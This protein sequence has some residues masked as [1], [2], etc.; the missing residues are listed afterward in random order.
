MILEDYRKRIDKVDDELLRLMN[1]RA[2]IVIEIER[3]K[4]EADLSLEDA[5]R[6]KLILDRVDARNPG[7]L[8]RL[9]VR[10]I[11]YQLINECKFGR[12]TI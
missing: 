9:A 3:M 7:P 8:H 11:F 6:E 12:I 1:L 5:E 10:N 2:Q 4:Q